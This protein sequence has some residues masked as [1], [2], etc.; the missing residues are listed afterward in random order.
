M[1]EGHALSPKC[2]GLGVIHFTPAC[3]LLDK[4]SHLSLLTP[5]EVGKYGRAH[6]ILDL[7]YKSSITFFG[8]G[9]KT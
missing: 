8:R 5:K 7:F 6:E 2:V 1:L 4:N 3:V 9:T